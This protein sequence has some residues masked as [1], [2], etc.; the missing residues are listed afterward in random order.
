LRIE[1]FEFGVTPSPSKS[2]VIVAED[3]NVD[4]DELSKLTS[5]LSVVTPKSIAA[6]LVEIRA[7][8]AKDPYINV[9]FIIV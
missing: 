6:E 3:K 8:E 9:F 7:K 5:L 1:P 4:G 2:P